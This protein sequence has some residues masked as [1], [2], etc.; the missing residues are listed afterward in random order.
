MSKTNKNPNY[1]QIKNIREQSF[2]ADI[3]KT[4]LDNFIRSLLV[5]WS[6]IAL[7]IL[8]FIVGFL[9]IKYPWS[10]FDRKLFVRCFVN[11]F[12]NAEI[13]FFFILKS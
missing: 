13:E 2:E 5:S 12:V 9:K 4:F 6:L 7:V 3:L 11:V 8:T 1:F 10:K